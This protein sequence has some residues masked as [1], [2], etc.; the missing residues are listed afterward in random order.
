M[1]SITMR[2]DDSLIVREIDGEI[3]AVDTL[4]NRVHQFNR[5]AA[6][7]WQ[8]TRDGAMPHAI[9]ATLATRFAVDEKT[10]LADVDETLTKMRF[11]NLLPT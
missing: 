7:I 10:A 9:A 1:T 3:V 8:M 2:E 4:S 5:T 6:L 11:L